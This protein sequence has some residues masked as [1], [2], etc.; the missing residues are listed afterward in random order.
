MKKILSFLVVVLAVLLNSCGK[1]V[2]LDVKLKAAQP[3]MNI[4]G[5]LDDNVHTSDSIRVLKS[6]SYLHP[7]DSVYVSN[8]TVS[9]KDES[10]KVWVFS[11]SGQ[12][13]YI[14][15]ADYKGI[16][17]GK[18]YT[19]EVLHEGVAYTATSK[20]DP[21]SSIPDMDPFALDSVEKR[22]PQNSF[23]GD[24]SG[25]VVSL[26]LIDDPTL[27][28]YYYM[29]VYR[30]DTLITSSKPDEGGVSVY[31]FDDKY[32]IGTAAP[33]QTTL[34]NKFQLND[35]VKVDLFTIDYP[36]LKYYE[37]L[38]IQTNNSGSIFD[39]PP[40]N[41]IGNISNGAVGYFYVSSSFSHRLI[42]KP[43]Q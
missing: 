2:E 30:N 39:G 17:V 33:I 26:F 13:Y 1:P 35:K 32:L 11:Y 42:V 41:I 10:G 37:A 15:P 7:A 25:F 28:N 9:V 4:F 5:R 24:T 18:S 12:G 20:A 21:L 19:M 34:F 29:N 31:T 23:G 16:I 14:P 22:T 36:T 8:A 27:K 6:V 3:Q 38:Q 43:K 40:A